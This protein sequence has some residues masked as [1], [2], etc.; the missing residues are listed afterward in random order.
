MKFF[1]DAIVSRD[2]IFIRERISRSHEFLSLKNKE[3]HSLV[4]FSIQKKDDITF[5]DGI[6]KPLKI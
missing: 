4:P 1:L 6:L 3:N 2:V 5:S